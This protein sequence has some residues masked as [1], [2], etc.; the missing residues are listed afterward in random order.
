MRVSWG[1]PST[2]SVGIT[3]LWFRVSCNG[4]G[5]MGHWLYTACSVNV[6]KTRRGMMTSADPKSLPSGSVLSSP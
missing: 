2:D 3:S 6:R 4:R 1:D 5:S